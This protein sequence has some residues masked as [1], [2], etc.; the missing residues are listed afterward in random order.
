[1]KYQ[2]PERKGV[3]STGYL[4]VAHNPMRNV[5]LFAWR[6]SRGAAC[7]EDIVP[8]DFHGIIQCDGRI[9]CPFPSVL[10]SEG[11]GLL[12]GFFK[13]G[14]PGGASR[15]DPPALLE[16]GEDVPSRLQVFNSI[17][18]RDPGALP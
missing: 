6:T 13:A 16:I 10:L 8:Q 5:S 2:D 3:C 1:M 11:R 18:H 15:I 12:D 14:K 7:L 17:S 4:W 9:Y